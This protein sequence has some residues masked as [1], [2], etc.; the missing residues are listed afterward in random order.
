MDIIV[1]L[2]SVSL[3]SKGL[4]KNHSIFIGWVCIAAKTEVGKTVYDVSSFVFFNALQGV[5]VVSKNKIR[6]LFDCIMCDL[7]LC[8][9]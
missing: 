8:V 2:Q 7:C 9:I 5:R 4:L 3:K 6:P 1:F